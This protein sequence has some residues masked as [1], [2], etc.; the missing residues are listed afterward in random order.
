MNLLLTPQIKRIESALPLFGSL[1]WRPSSVNCV[2]GENGTGKSSIADLICRGDGLTWEEGFS[3]SDVDILRYD[4]NYVSLFFNRE[5]RIPGIFST[6]GVNRD[7]AGQIRKLEASVSANS[8][9]AAEFDRLFLDLG[10]DD[11]GAFKLFKLTCWRNA[12]GFRKEYGAALRGSLSNSEKFANMILSVRTNHEESAE[13]KLERLQGLYGSAFVKDAVPCEPLFIPDG[14][15]RCLELP[16]Q[17]LLGQSFSSDGGTAFSDFV[18]SLH[19]QD[20]VWEGKDNYLDASGDTCPFCGQKLPD[21]FSDRLMELFDENY[22]AKITAL[23][24]YETAFKA[25]VNRIFAPM[26]RWTDNPFPGVKT[27]RIPALLGE[28]KK[29]IDEALAVIRSKLS[30]PGNTAAMPDLEDILTSL[31]DEAQFVNQQIMK[32]NEVIQKQKSFQKVCSQLAWEYL[33]D[34][35]ALPVRDY[36]QTIQKNDARR[37]TAKRMKE[38]L[39]AE[40]R[41]LEGQIRELEGETEN[42]REA[43]EAINHILAVSRYQ[44]FSLREKDGADG[45]YEIVRPDGSLADSLSDGEYR[46]LTFLYFCQQA[47]KKGGWTQIPGLPKNMDMD[48][49][50]GTQKISRPRLLVID[51]PV[52]GMDRRGK[53]IAGSMIAHLAKIC[54]HEAEA[55]PGAPGIAQLFFF[56]HDIEFYQGFMENWDKLNLPESCRRQV[57]WANLRKVN[58][59]S[60]LSIRS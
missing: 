14:L 20:W 50:I 2:F 46:M 34:T 59:I 55:S 19:A 45:L 25:E 32:H 11:E 47:L 60:T 54:L 51:D 5:G 37:Q 42:S 39:L 17:E 10:R 24:A 7:I 35:C 36:Y 3:S 38:D 48:I 18:H 49:G 4:Q 13:S 21:S 33:A 53:K 43:V 1:C 28:L 29:R 52:N 12:A 9:R 8:L 57:T 16:G 27:S 40:N 31:R 22:E 26:S 23:R 44:G 15:L 56:T 41:N 6:Q 58:G 30:H